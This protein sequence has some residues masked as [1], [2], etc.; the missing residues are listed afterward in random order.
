MKKLLFFVVFSLLFSKYSQAE[1][2][3]TYGHDSARTFS[4]SEALPHGDYSPLW[5]YSPPEGYFTGGNPVVFKGKV[6]MSIRQR[7]GHDGKLICLNEVNGE[8][9]WI[10]DPGFYTG[11]SQVTAELTYNSQGEQVERIYVTGAL[12]ANPF[13][14]SVFCLDATNGQVIWQNGDIGGR[15]WNGSPAISGDNLFLTHSAPESGTVLACLNKITGA[16][17]WG[18]DFGK[19]GDPRVIALANN[20]I[21]IR[22][23]YLYTQPYYRWVGG[24]WCLDTTG[25][26]QWQ[27]DLGDRLFMSWRGVAADDK[28]FY[29]VLSG[30]YNDSANLIMALSIDT[31]EIVWQKTIINYRMKAPTVANNRLVIPADAMWPTTPYSKIFIFDSSSGIILNE[32]PAGGTWYYSQA[33]VAHDKL[34]IAI[35]STLLIYDLSSGAMLW[36][37]A[38]GGGTNLINP[39]TVAN[40]KF[41]AVRPDLLNAFGLSNVP[42]VANINSENIVITSS[43]IT[44]TIIQATATDSDGDVLTYK[45]LENGETVKD[46]TP[47][48]VDGICELSI[49]I[50]LNVGRGDHIY[51][52]E[53]ND[54]KESVFD[55]IVLTVEN[56]APVITTSGEG[57][58]SIGSEIYLGGTFSDYDGGTIS[59]KWF[60]NDVLYFE[61]S[62]PAISGGTPVSLPSF[63]IPETLALGDYIVRLEISD[64]VSSFPLMQCFPIKIVD[65]EAPTLRPEA[66]TYML[67][68]PNHQMVDIMIT[69]NASDNSGVCKLAAT[70]QSSESDN[71]NGDGNTEAD[72]TKPIINNDMGTI[73]FQLRAERS[74]KGVG[75]TYLIT[76]FA[77][78][79]A[80]N[81]TTAEIKIVAPH[82][83]GN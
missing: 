55:S 11:M 38:M 63:R 23:L 80:E 16:T 69:A 45:W 46:S 22:Y 53:V 14:S 81:I 79:S 3:V 9:V 74:G 27:I 2:W 33:T 48:G 12:E 57:T 13:Q 28:N 62:L 54:G 31:G 40:K 50:L 32:I 67:W 24:L 17:L 20:K 44:T 64:G 52:L 26:G 42:P 19:A 35:P 36:Q 83:R 7:D 68:P 41:Y 56:S 71:A 29:I 25:T 39:I 34:F 18:R 51:T 8:V 66:N 72:Y 70:I 77:S 47:V 10:F 65:T 58:Y 6:F 73:S 21:L 61:S 30:G 78:D 4:T 75:R 5:H 76:I 60:I 1:D 49:G 59:Y 37:Y 15:F 82:N 43:E